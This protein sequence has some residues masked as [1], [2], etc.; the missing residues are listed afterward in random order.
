MA[1]SSYYVTADEVSEF[2]CRSEGYGAT[3]TPTLD[4]VNN[5][6]TKVAARINLTLSATVLTSAAL[7]HQRSSERAQ[8]CIS[9]SGTW[10]SRHAGPESNR[11]KLSTDHQLLMPRPSS[12]SSALPNARNASL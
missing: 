11:A 1:C 10:S 8:F 3:G 5:Y 9:S 12:S 7:R 4:D 6:I 2:L